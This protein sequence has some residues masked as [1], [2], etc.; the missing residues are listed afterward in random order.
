[1]I[2]KGT[3]CESNGRLAA[4]A[5]N[6]DSGVSPTLSPKVPLCTADKHVGGLRGALL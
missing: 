1:M 4:D 3:E 2:N 6:I 5:S